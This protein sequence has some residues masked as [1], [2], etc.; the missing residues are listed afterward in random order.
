MIYGQPF[1]AL[2]SEQIYNIPK[3]TKI[4]REFYSNESMYLDSP[5]RGGIRP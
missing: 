4:S 3:T 2:I 5:V 1:A